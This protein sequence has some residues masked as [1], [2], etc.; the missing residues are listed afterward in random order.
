MSKQDQYE[1]YE[2][3]LMLVGGDLHWDLLKDYWK[4]TFFNIFE[5]R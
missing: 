4:I 5:S 3:E 1:G 2:D